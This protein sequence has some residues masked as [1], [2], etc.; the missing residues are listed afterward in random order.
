MKKRKEAKHDTASGNVFPDIAANA[1][2]PHVAPRF[3]IPSSRLGISPSQSN[4]HVWRNQCCSRWSG[5]SELQNGCSVFM[6]SLLSKNL[7][8]IEP[9]VTRLEYS[10]CLGVLTPLE[11][12][13][14]FGNH[15]PN[16]NLSNICSGLRT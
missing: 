3:W 4:A 10:R 16:P 5:D 9:F 11:P 14:P 15:L 12:P 8:L 2:G 13:L 6:P 1:T 7:K